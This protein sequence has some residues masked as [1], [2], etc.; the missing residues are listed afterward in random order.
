MSA[1]Q[2][3]EAVKIPFLAEL[4]SEWQGHIARQ[5]SSESVRQGIAACESR[6]RALELLH[7]HLRRD[8]ARV[9]RIPEER[10]NA[11]TSLLRMGL[12]SLMA[13]ELK[14]RIETDFGVRLSPA[15]L[16]QGPSVSDLAEWICGEVWSATTTSSSSDEAAAPLPSAS[17]VDT[18]S[19]DEVDAMLARVLATESTG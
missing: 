9:L 8:I 19:D 3:P 2:F 18:M 12:D 11:K 1:T 10:L 7:E 6:T 4:S 13:V 16:L 5:A 17:A 14:N 15:R